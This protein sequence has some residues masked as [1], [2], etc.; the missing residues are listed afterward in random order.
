MTR[1]VRQT[2]PRPSYLVQHIYSPPP[3][4]RGF[5][6]DRADPVPTD[7]P[8]LERLTSQG[9]SLDEALAQTPALLNATPRPCLGNQTAAEIFYP[10]RDIFQPQFTLT[11]RKEIRDLIQ[12][13]AERIRARMERCGH[14][15]QGTAWRRA[16]EQWLEGNGLMTVHP[17]TIVL[18]H[19]P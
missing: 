18:P 14:Q 10:A 16:V 12:D 5:P 6:N 11:Q 4:V 17:P 2:V 15:P 9:M 19:H 1:K 3:P 8:A 7:A 13:Q